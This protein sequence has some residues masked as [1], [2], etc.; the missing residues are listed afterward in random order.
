VASEKGDI[1]IIKFLMDYGIDIMFCLASGHNR[2]EIVKFFMENGAD[3]YAYD[4]LLLR[5]S[6]YKSNLPV[7]K[8]L[9]EK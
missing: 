8:F 6:Y 5:S 2:L 7:T 1:H 4:D 3:I 9:I